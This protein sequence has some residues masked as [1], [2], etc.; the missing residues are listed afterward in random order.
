MCGKHNTVTQFGTSAST[1]QPQHFL[2]PKESSSTRVLRG[3]T[4]QS[5][6]EKSHLSNKVSQQVK[7]MENEADKL[8]PYWKYNSSSNKSLISPIRSSTSKIHKACVD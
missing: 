4:N 5:T 6:T 2:R 3:D 7:S 1:E 8:S